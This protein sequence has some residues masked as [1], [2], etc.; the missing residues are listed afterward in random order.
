MNADVEGTLCQGLKTL[1]MAASLIK[2]YLIISNIQ[3]GPPIPP[4]LISE[5]D[6]ES[7]V[8]LKSPQMLKIF[9][10]SDAE[11][12]KKYFYSAT[13]PVYAEMFDFVCGSY[14]LSIKFRG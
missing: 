11:I 3:P 9:Y 13:V 2:I 1:L 14:P 12:H 6:I 8:P 4:G 7:F 5:G 10:R